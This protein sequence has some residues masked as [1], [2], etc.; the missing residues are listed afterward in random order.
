[1][2]FTRNLTVTG[3]VILVI[4][5]VLGTSAFNEVREYL[6][7]RDGTSAAQ[8]DIAAGQLKLKCEGKPHLWNRYA[9]RLW[10]SRYGVDVEYVRH[11]T[12]PSYGLS[13]NDAYNARVGQ[14][15]AARLG[16]FSLDD[17]WKDH[18]NEA[19]EKAE[20]ECQH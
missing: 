13:Y 2:R 20:A 10:K 3:L 8:R 18:L 11:N 1:M 19:I 5:F 17:V 9:A 14:E 16:E 6:G 15:L 4:T 12:S 7:K